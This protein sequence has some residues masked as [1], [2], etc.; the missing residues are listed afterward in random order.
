MDDFTEGDQLYHQYMWLFLDGSDTNY[1]RRI[2]FGTKGQNKYAY[3]A[4]L[5]K[6][7]TPNGLQI[8]IEAGQMR[9]KK[10][11]YI[12]DQC[13]RIAAMLKAWKEDPLKTMKELGVR[14]WPPYTEDEPLVGRELE[15]FKIFLQEHDLASFKGLFSKD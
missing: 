12:Q 13:T 2:P 14:P 15:H 10:E 3:E 7:D 8:M 5:K 1:I 6:Y 4:I 9:E 11:E